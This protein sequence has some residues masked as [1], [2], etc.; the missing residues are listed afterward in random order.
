MPVMVVMPSSQ[1]SA[2]STSSW[3]QRGTLLV[4]VLFYLVGAE[5]KLSLFTPSR[6]WC[7]LCVTVDCK[8]REAENYFWIYFAVSTTLNT[9]FGCK[10]IKKINYEK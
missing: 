10:V 3:R 7:P 2:N 6:G 8:P 1:S 9:T 4:G 5:E